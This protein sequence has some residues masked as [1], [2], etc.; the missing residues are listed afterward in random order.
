MSAAVIIGIVGNPN[1]GKTTLFNAL[2]G[3]TQ[4]V[5]N[6]PGVTVERAEGAY[7]YNGVTVRV[8]D[9][10]GIYSLSAATLDETVARDFIFNEQPALIVNIADAV[11]LQRN[12]YLSLQLL[13]MKIPCVLALNMMDVAKQR[14]MNIDVKELAKYLDCPVVGIVASRRQGLEALREAIEQARRGGRASAV[15][16]YYPE[17]VENEI[18]RLTSCFDAAGPRYSDRRWLAVKLL[19][20]DAR[21]SELAAAAPVAALAAAGRKH[22]EAVLGEPAEVVIADSRYGFINALCRKVVD[23]RQMIRKTVTDVLDR[24]FLSR[25]FGAPVFFLAMYLVFWLT[26]NLSGCFID[27]F[28]QAVGALSVDALGSML[29]GWGAPRFL[30]TLLVDGI[31][32]G[33]QTIATFIPPI[34]CMFLCL[35]LLEDSGYMARAAFVM[36]GLMRAI[37]LPGK[38]FIPLLIGF[39]CNVPAILATR[40]LDSRRDRILTVLMIPLMSCGARFPVYA[41]FAAAFFPDSGGMVI[42]S[43]YV[44]G[45]LL[46]IGTVFLARRLISASEDAAFILEL[47]PYHV[48]TLTSILT[49]AG[50]RLQAFLMKAA[51]AILPAIIILS[52][53]NSLGV[54]GTFGNQGTERSLLSLVG[55]ATVPVFKPMGVREDNWPAAVGIFTGIFAKET[56]IGTL[57]SLYRQEEPQEQAVQPFEAK[58]LM[59]Q[60]RQAARTIP[61]N[62]SRLRLPLTGAAAAPAESSEIEQAL[63]RHFDGKAGAYA[64]LLLVLLYMPCV[65]AMSAVQRE[66]GTRWMVFAVLYLSG[67]AWVVATVFYQLARWTVQPAASIGWLFFCGCLSAAAIGAMRWRGAADRGQNPGVPAA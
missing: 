41:I 60:L 43:L 16:I 42:F 23:T 10:P 44:L 26:I 6:W 64:Y 54:D 29:R 50:T 4:R 25:F 30:E 61:E 52:F 20:D 67:L 7:E 34:F 28:D 2:T 40:T 14:R 27:F 39:G 33:I 24:I 3:G 47:P 59:R 45:I 22:I 49:H 36:D 37:G 62:I 48:P 65:A 1:C 18:S 55:R 32:G 63:R 51:T 5:G 21:A 46:S 53:L 15:K 13:E 12:L 66:L 58:R 8:V 31:G 38:A 56:V 57:E 35:S 11:N 19:E 9:L 17:E